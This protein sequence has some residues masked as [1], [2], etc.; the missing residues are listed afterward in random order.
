MI[1][2]VRKVRRIL[3]GH[4][5]A[6]D[7]DATTATKTTRTDRT[8]LLTRILA[9]AEDPNPN[10][11]VRHPRR[12]RAR[13]L[14]AV[15]ITATLVA[16]MV[17]QVGLPRRAAPSVAQAA[18]PPPL[19]YQAVAGSAREVL[20]TLAGRI[21]A[22]EAPAR[23]SARYRYVRTRS[24]DLSTRIEG[25]QVRSVV[26]PEIR[27]VWRAPDGSGRLRTVPGEPWFPTEDR[28]LVWEEEG[29]P[30][31]DPADETFPAGGLGSMYPA[32]LPAATSALADLLTA[33]H[34]MENGPA[35]TLVAVTDLYL[36]QVPPAS[37]RAAL[38]DILAATAD[39]YLQ[40]STVDRAGRPALAVAVD[41]AMSGLPTR[42]ALLLDPADGR[43]L[44][45]EQTLT[46]TAGALGV[47]IPSVISYTAFLDAAR[48]DATQPPPR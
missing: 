8:A 44:G 24:W 41:S 7:I 47:P 23:S 33:G 13:W 15:G 21:R 6:G 16:I 11:D 2:D 29:R 31:A 37:V 26:L 14:V 19:A 1:G 46:T 35:E 28:R 42:Y 48:T 30:L 5:P 25:I 43:L 22:T 10:G 40:G 20:L 17:T 27:E 3:D 9:T 38:L 4:D 36:E 32:D 34:P 12:P 39:L 45:Q 18:T